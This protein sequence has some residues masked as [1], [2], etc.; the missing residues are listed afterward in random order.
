[1]G[2]RRIV[3]AVVG[4]VVLATVLPTV[5]A[6]VGSDATGGSPSM[7]VSLTGA[8]TANGT[9][10]AGER[11]RF[12]PR[13]DDIAPVSTFADAGGYA[14]DVDPGVNYT[15]E[16][17][18]EYESDGTT[19]DT[20]TS[21]TPYPTDSTTTDTSTSPT[22]YPTDGTTTDTSTSPTPYPTDGTTTDPSTPPP[23]PDDG[24]PDVYALGAVTVSDDATRDFAIPAG[25]NLS[26]DVV[27]PDGDPLG[28][29]RVI[30][31]HRADTGA[32]GAVL[33]GNTISSGSFVPSGAATPGVEVTGT[34]DV[35]VRPPA[36]RDDLAEYHTRLEVDEDRSLP[37]EL[38]P[39]ANVSVRVQYGS[40][41]DAEA[42][43]GDT[44]SWLGNNGTTHGEQARLDGAGAS[45]N[46]TLWKGGNYTTALFQGDRGL[47]RPAPGPVDGRPDTYVLEAGTVGGDAAPTYSVPTEATRVNVTVLNGSDVPY[48]EGEVQFV[49]VRSGGFAPLQANLTAS[50][51][52]VLPGR[53]TPGAELT[54]PVLIRAE[55]ADGNSAMRR[56]SATGDRRNV[57][58][59][60][61]DRTWLGVEF[62]TARGTYLTNGTVLVERASDGQAIAAF[63]EPIEGSVFAGTTWSNV[64]QTVSYVQRATGPAGSHD[65]V[66]D[67]LALG[68]LR[69]STDVF[70][71]AT[72]P[73][74]HVVNVSVVDSD[75]NP[76]ENATV[77]VRDRSP[78]IIQAQSETSGT[79][80][81]GPANA[82]LR[83]TTDADGLLHLENRTTPGIELAG[84]V[85]LRVRPPDGG[86]FAEDVYRRRANVTAPENRSFAVELAAAESGGGGGGDLSTSTSEPTDT[87]TATNE[88]VA[89]ETGV[90]V[91]RPSLSIASDELA[92][93][94]VR[95]GTT[96]NRTLELTNDGT[97]P[98]TVSRIEVEGAAFTRQGDVRSVAPGET[99]SVQVRFSPSSNESAT[100]RLT[101]AHNGSTAVAAV[102]LSGRGV[103]SAIAVSPTAV[104]FGEVRVGENVTRTI[105]ISN[106][107]T[108]P[109]RLSALDLVEAPGVA[110]DSPANLTVRPGEA[111]TATVTFAPR[112]SGSLTGSLSVGAP[113]G[114]LDVALEGRAV[115]PD[116]QVGVEALRFGD[117]T[118]GEALNRTLTVRNAGEANLTVDRAALVGATPDAFGVDPDGGFTLAPGD[119]RSLTVTFGPPGPGTYSATLQVFGADPASRSDVWLSNTDSVVR[120][121]GETTNNTTRVNVTARNVTAGE[122]VEVNVSTTRSVDDEVGVDSLALSVEEGG[123]FALNVTES[124]S[125][126]VT[127]AN[128]SVTD[129][130]R[131]LGYLR[132]D[133]TIP[134]SA[135]GGVNFTFRVSKDRLAASDTDPGDVV[136][137]RFANGTWTELPTTIVAETPTHWILRGDSPGLSDFVVGGEQA[138]F[139]L[140]RALVSVSRVELGDAVAVRVRISNVG[141]ADG[142]FTAELLLNGQVVEDRDVT[143]AAEGT[144]Q[145]TFEREFGD[146][147]NYSVR[148]NDERAGNVTVVVPESANGTAT[149]VVATGTV[150]PDGTTAPGGTATTVVAE[151]GALG[152]GVPTLGG[153]VALIVALLG[154]L[155][156]YRRG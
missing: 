106:D 96:S 151:P 77:T 41:Q 64:T 89:N 155:V 33:T 141:G 4:A 19:T 123:D 55:T 142:T 156:L 150:P 30:V 81:T 137:H 63:D 21:P 6:L 51:Q 101:V 94:D 44:V 40:G 109:L 83:A 112:E 79:T 43:A 116:L 87:E 91:G 22:P 69:Q 75:G 145:A 32:A 125:S 82:S 97:A 127:E 25:H 34:V 107:G 46:V 153:V 59:Y 100:G 119:E 2:E 154:G 135:I 13:D 56:F 80:V 50:G 8:V 17:R 35:V 143:V 118:A 58:L 124:N 42:A 114:S 68:R 36:G 152:V 5:G 74:G 84:D 102:N 113:G 20:S 72:L 148:V 111:R 131:G 10:S 120:T 129:G 52:A 138:K 70:G 139:E 90:D 3:L 71:T 54:G 140:L 16:F 136:L 29:A 9:G 39:A 105:R 15:V 92:F 115:A 24:V 73:S 134:D 60:V 57:T 38:R 122:T 67:L 12:L 126:A 26:I 117:V 27:G 49:H 98:L 78:A 28:D 93:G 11:L 104:D 53:T 62:L 48:S 61:V 45:R 66:P 144:R 110:L 14:V 121:D 85:S 147:G 108:A 31:H 130:T 132:V 128:F 99:R 88:T 95:V 1:M 149:A 133:H 37:V 23:Y 7:S 18:Q 103:R 65:G 76:V 146:P 86:G 47:P